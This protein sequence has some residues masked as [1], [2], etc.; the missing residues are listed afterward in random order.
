MLSVLQDS[1][2]PRALTAF[3]ELLSLPG[4]MQMKRWEM[5]PIFFAVK[6]EKDVE[7]EI[8]PHPSLVVILHWFVSLFINIGTRAATGTGHSPLNSQAAMCLITGFLY[9]F[10]CF[11]ACYKKTDGTS[12]PSGAR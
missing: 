1:E 12:E 10:A 3:D 5:G 11:R 7:I 2:C 6:K 4:S 9:E 8:V